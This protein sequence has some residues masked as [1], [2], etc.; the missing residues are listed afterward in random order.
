MVT[1]IVDRHKVNFSV[2]SNKLIGFTMKNFSQLIPNV[3]P[4]IMT[5]MLVAHTLTVVFLA[6]IVQ[7]F[8]VI[9][10]VIDGIYVPIFAKKCM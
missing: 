1:K 7:T 2:V 3:K 9:V 4:N 10:F 6:F 8:T 5:V